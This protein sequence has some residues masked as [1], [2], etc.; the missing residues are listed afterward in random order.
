MLVSGVPLPARGLCPVNLASD[1]T[2]LIGLVSNLQLGLG[3][4][5]GELCCH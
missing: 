2:S 3:G 4:K 5:Q 1:M